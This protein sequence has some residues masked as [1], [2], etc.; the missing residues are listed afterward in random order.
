MDTPR[1]RV[2]VKYGEAPFS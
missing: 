1:M 2:V